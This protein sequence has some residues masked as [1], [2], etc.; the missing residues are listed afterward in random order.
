MISELFEKLLRGG[1][2]KQ[3]RSQIG[4]NK[5]VFDGIVEKSEQGVKIAHGI[6]YAYGSFV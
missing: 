6:E 2:L 3:N 5:A 1:R 4:G